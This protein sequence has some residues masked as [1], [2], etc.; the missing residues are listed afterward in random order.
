MEKLKFWKKEEPSVPPLETRPMRFTEEP[1]GEPA[2]QPESFHPSPSMSGPLPPSSG[3]PFGMPPQGSGREMDL[4]LSKL[5][6][7]RALLASM[8]QRLS[9]LE[10]IAGQEEE[11]LR[12]KKIYY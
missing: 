3:S 6:I 2:F 7:I 4:I 1:F 12:K 5:D 9:N 10:K 11:D 8:E